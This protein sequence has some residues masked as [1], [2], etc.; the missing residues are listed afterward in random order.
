LAPAG[1]LGCPGQTADRN[2]GK[3]VGGV[4][5]VAQPAIGGKAPAI[6]FGGC[7]TVKN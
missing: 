6:L 2:R 7:L 1:N 4:A 3:L 5:V